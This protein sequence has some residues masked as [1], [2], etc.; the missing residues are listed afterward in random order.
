MTQPIV[1]IGGGH[2]GL[3]AAALLAKAG[4]RVLLLE[5]ADQLGGLAAGSSFH[6]GFQTTGIL[7]DTTAV[8]SDI[9]KALKLDVHGLKL[10]SEPS[11]I[12]I[13]S[14]DQESIRLHGDDVE[15]PLSSE[16]IDQYKR[17]RDFLRRLRPVFRRLL[18]QLPPDP[19]GSIWPLARTA[20]GI[21][22]LGAKD[23]T[24]LLRIGPMC[25]A[26]W[27]RDQFSNERLGA[28]LAQPALWGGW[29]GPWSP[30]TAANL[31]LYECIANHEI[32]GGPAALTQALEASARSFGVQ[33][34]TGAAVRRIRTDSNGIQGVTLEDGEE[35][36][37][38]VVGASCDPKQTFLDL[39][40]AERLSV[41]LSRDIGAIRTRG[42]TAKVHLALKGPLTDRHGNTVEAMRTGASLDDLER[43]FDPI[44]YRQMSTKPILDVRVPS[45]QDSSLA[46]E[47][48]HMVSII[49]HF[50][51]YHLEGG[52]TDEAR[53]RLEDSIINELGS[54]C[55]DV[56]EQIV[57]KE[58]LSPMDLSERLRLTEGHV[59]HGEHAP[60]QLLF[61]RP[62]IQCGK[63]ATPIKGLFLCGSGSHPG[64]GISCAPGALGARAILK[65]G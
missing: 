22:R 15:G 53:S 40:G 63:Y 38:Q 42:T 35:I 3:T 23:M 36:D 29:N 11:S 57:G 16:D 32:I 55:P 41:R 25:V 8:R 21:R 18:N 49:S 51:P 52:W 5:A 62:T 37:A 39:I 12:L 30:G 1:M 47:G 10:S 24:E 65:A 50:A 64:G 58:V 46:P 4:R 60:D 13:P 17:H 27:M 9:V 6:E 44:K 20:I 33:I 59:L 28:A 19:Y 34:R 43:A 61:M 54:Y 2:N 56:K 31:L 26:D 48:H 14:S 7:H 45:V